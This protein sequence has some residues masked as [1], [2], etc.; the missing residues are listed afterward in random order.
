MLYINCLFWYGVHLIRNNLNV[1]AKGM[2]DKAYSYSGKIK[3]LSAYQEMVILYTLGDLNLQVGD[4]STS[5][6]HFRN[7][8]VLGTGISSFDLPYCY[9][10]LAAVYYKLGAYDQA[11]R[12]A[13]EGQK[14]A[15]M[16]NNFDVE[17]QASVLLE[18]LKEKGN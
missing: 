17:Y 11:R 13:V 5:L 4:L 16:F 2:L 7:A 6:K 14:M 9:L 3:G 18:E 12:N 8:I 10:K 1:K 15:K